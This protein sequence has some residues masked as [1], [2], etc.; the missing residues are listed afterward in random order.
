[1]A[2]LAMERPHETRVLA[3]DVPRA[4]CVVENRHCGMLSDHV[5]Q[6]EPLFVASVDYPQRLLVLEFL[7]PAS[8]AISLVGADAAGG[9]QA[10]AGAAT[11]L[12][13]PF[14]RN[15]AAAQCGTSRPCKSRF[16]GWQLDRRFDLV[17]VAPLVALCLLPP[18]SLCIVVANDA[19]KPSRGQTAGE[20]TQKRPQ[21]CGEQGEGCIGRRGFGT[22]ARPWRAPR[23]LWARRTY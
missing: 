11:Q 13:L 14:A 23:A 21:R 7:R 12:A 20:K 15:S 2:A 9:P 22:K 1:M 17:H 10:E 8:A 18:A 6:L 3:G 16:F 4:V 5:V 19:S